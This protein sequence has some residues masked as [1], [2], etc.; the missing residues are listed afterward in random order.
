M[1]RDGFTVEETVGGPGFDL[2]KSEYDEDKPGDAANA[3]AR[4]DQESRDIFTYVT[5]THTADKNFHSFS[6]LASNGPQQD[7]SEDEDDFDPPRSEDESPPPPQYVSRASI[8]PHMARRSSDR[9]NTF[10][11]HW[12]RFSNAFL[13]LER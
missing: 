2:F 10:S 5:R 6:A 3:W 1:L 13:G 4:L 9:W 8:A 12:V 7:M 11:H